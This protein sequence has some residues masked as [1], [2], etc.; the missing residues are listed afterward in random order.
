MNTCTIILPIDKKRSMQLLA[1]LQM[2]GRSAVIPLKEITKAIPKSTLFALL[3]KM[4]LLG[5][6]VRQ[7]HGFDLFV[8]EKG[9]DLESRKQ[10]KVMKLNAQVE[11]AELD[12]LSF[13]VFT[14]SI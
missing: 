7:R 4:R 5:Q 13:A 3:Y 11:I 12:G 6:L 10:V 9:L 14:K 1:L 2:F 8:F